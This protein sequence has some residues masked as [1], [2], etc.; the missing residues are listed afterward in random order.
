MD[1]NFVVSY[2][3]PKQ[4]NN[5]CRIAIYMYMKYICLSV[6]LI[7]PRLCLYAWAEY[8]MEWLFNMH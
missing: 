3:P 5:I 1:F 6:L 8:L 4:F 2:F 7:F